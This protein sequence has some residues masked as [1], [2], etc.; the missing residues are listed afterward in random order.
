MGGIGK[1]GGRKNG[2]QYS[3]I[4][5]TKNNNFKNWARGMEKYWSAL[6]E[7]GGQCEWVIY[8]S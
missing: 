1:R 8:V 4:K 6:A 5:F 3:Y 2:I 7:G